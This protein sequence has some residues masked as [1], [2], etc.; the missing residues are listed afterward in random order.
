MHVT[1]QSGKIRC[2]KEMPQNQENLGVADE[3]SHTHA[4]RVWA[5][6]AHSRQILTTPPLSCASS[7]RLTLSRSARL[8]NGFDKH[9]T[10]SSFKRPICSAYPLTN[11]TLRFLSC[12]L[13]V[14]AKT[15]PFSLGKIMSVI[16]KSISQF[17][18]YRCSASAES[19]ALKTRYPAPRNTS[20]VT[21][22][23][24]ASSSTRRI[25]SFLLVVCPATQHESA[26]SSTAAGMQLA[27]SPMKPL[28]IES[29]CLHFS[30]SNLHA[31]CL[32]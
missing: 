28:P 32:P 24:N 12:F 15:L 31:P 30:M 1:R 17:V 20:H 14:S 19:L 10:A 11:K 18:S 4:H 7:T 5:T 8:E 16:S 29:T 21:S 3:L 26:T 23:T 13:S 22:R 9:A 27:P 6:C 25:V 2:G